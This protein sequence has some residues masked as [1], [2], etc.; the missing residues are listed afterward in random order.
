MKESRYSTR[1]IGTDEQAL[2]QDM[3]K[4]EFRTQKNAWSAQS[5]LECFDES[6]IIVG[7]F[8]Y[9]KLIGFSIIYN[10]AFST[11]LLTI[12]VDP[13][14]QG[15]SLGYLL[16]KDTLKIAHENKDIECFLEVRVSNQ[17]AINLY[18]K[19]G[20]KNVGVR[21][22]Y[23]NPVGDEPAEDAYTMHLEDISEALKV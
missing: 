15:R 21:K 14:Y 3:E 20:F 7:L 5:L 6:Y 10:T 1:I 13:D 2:V 23:Y 17:V 12:G 9:Q 4:I 8:D 19:M 18:T 16:L 11:D 22:G